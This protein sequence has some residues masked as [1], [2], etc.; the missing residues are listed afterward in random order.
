[1]NE[2]RN[3]TPIESSNIKQKSQIKEITEGIGIGF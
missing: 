2:L 3:T 1:M